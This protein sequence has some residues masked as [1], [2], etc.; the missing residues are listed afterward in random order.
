MNA[1]TRFAIP[2]R[3]RTAAPGRWEMIE[4]SSARNEILSRDDWR[5]EKLPIRSVVVSPAA[6]LRYLSNWR[7][8][9]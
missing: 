5:E 3:T 8:T 2:L 4:G 7:N 9:W 1:M 6:W